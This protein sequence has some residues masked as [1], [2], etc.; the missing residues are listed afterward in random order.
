MQTREQI[1][2]KYAQMGQVIPDMRDDMV[3]VYPSGENHVIVEFVSSGTAPDGNKWKLPICTIFTI[4][5]GLIA[6]DSTYYD[7][8]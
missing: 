5:D 7:R 1:V 8:G 4:E 2:E 3:Q 6:R